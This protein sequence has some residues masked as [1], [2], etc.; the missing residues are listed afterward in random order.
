LDQAGL[1]PFRVVT[2]ATMVI[3]TVWVAT[4]SSGLLQRAVV[5]MRGTGYWLTM[6]QSWTGVATVSKA[7]S[8]SVVLGISFVGYLSL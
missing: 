3:T 7:G 5:S 4:A 6:I 2:V 1:R 8:Q